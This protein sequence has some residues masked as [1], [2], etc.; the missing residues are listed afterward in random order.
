MLAREH[1][2]AELLAL[3]QALPARYEFTGAGY[4]LTATHPDL[5]AERSVLSY[6]IVTGSN[7]GTLCGFVAFLGDNELTLE[8]HA[9]G[10]EPFPASFRDL[11]VKVVST[12]EE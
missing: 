1:L 6:P 8:C 7:R 3:V 9:F 5:P 4:Y 11:F 2:S 10:T 12:N